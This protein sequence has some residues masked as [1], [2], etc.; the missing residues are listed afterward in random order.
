MATKHKK[1]GK[2]YMLSLAGAIILAMNVLGI[3]SEAS[4]G[5]LG[6]MLMLLG[7]TFMIRES[8]P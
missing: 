2:G 3:P 4:W 7:I 5:M 8:C 1:L 6:I